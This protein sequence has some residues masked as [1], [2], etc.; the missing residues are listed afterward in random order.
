MLGRIIF[1]LF[2]ILI[3]SLLFAAPLLNDFSYWGQMD[4]DQFVAWNAIGRDTFLRYQQIPL[5]NPYVNGG[6][7]LFAH[8]H[9][10]FLSPF[11]ILV[12]LFGAYTG[13]KI[14]AFLY[15][16]IGLIGMFL[17]GRQE[18]MSP[19]AAL[20]AAALFMLNSVYALHVTEGHTEWLV[21]ALLPWLFYFFQK[22]LKQ[23]SAIP[24][25]ICVFS[26]ILL[27]GS[28]DVFSI[29]VAF[30]LVYAGLKSFSVSTLKPLAVISC[31]LAGT[32][33]L[34]AVKLVPMLEFL[35]QFPRLTVDNS[36][37]PWPVL[38]KILLSRQQAVFDLLDIAQTRKMGIQY[39]WHEYGAYIGIIPLALA[40]G[41]MLR[42]FK[43][44][45]PLVCSGMVFL[46]IAL[47][48][49]APVNIW[50]VLHCFP[51]WDSQKVPSRYILGFMFVAALMAG[52]AFAALEDRLHVLS[53]K[54]GRLITYVPVLVLVFV[55]CDLFAVNRP[56]FEQAFTVIP[57]AVTRNPE[58]VQ[59]YRRAVLFGDGR[60]RSSIYPIFLS[61]SGILEAY[62]VVEVKRDGVRAIGE[63][64]YQ[65]EVFLTRPGGR[66]DI[67]YFSPN[68]VVVKV[69]ALQ[70]NVLVMNQNYY[71]GWRVR[72]EEK[73]YPAESYKGMISTPV[74]AGEAVYAFYYLPK[75]F[76]IGL[77]V[78]LSS[79]LLL[80][81]FCRRNSQSFP[82]ENS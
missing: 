78:S 66:A 60:S 30:M 1:P 25:A 76:L 3:L 40:L 11:Y 72:S 74:S 32:A 81:L 75:S 44:R 2:I 28:V 38:G 61:N 53:R 51:F 31:I 10:P 73:T 17:L 59:R 16:F 18:Q 77:V 50:Q 9:A 52:H 70:P 65:G 63:D 69:S 34:C 35:R 68:K 4:W 37:T 64:G 21:M 45:W 48:R 56:I 24:A 39:L 54:G 7:V 55:V 29:S 43:A 23:V 27:N 19:L 12:L 71:T 13:L 22:S 80:L 42:M 20:F 82:L 14:Q 67:S 49:N 33:L 57:I 62:E 36:G 8:P 6:N 47:G 5:W 41:G 79:A 58:F 15:L 26:L 46:F